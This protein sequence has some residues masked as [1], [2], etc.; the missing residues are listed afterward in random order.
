MVATAAAASTP[1][2]SKRWSQL[3]QSSG[4]SGPLGPSALPQGVAP[5]YPE[6]HPPSPSHTASTPQASSSVPPPFQPQLQQPLLQMPTTRGIYRWMPKSVSPPTLKN[7]AAAGP[8]DEDD[9]HHKLPQQH[10]VNQSQPD[11]RHRTSAGSGTS[12]VGAS[13]FGTKTSG[14]LKESVQKPPTWPPAEDFPRAESTVPND[15]SSE[16]SDIYRNNDGKGTKASKQSPQ[17]REGPEQISYADFVEWQRKLYSNRL[18]L[19]IPPTPQSYAS[20]QQATNQQRFGGDQRNGMNSNPDNDGKGTQASNGHGYGNV[21]AYGNDYGP[22]AMLDPSIPDRYIPSPLSSY[23]LSPM[24]HNPFL[25]RFPPAEESPGSVPKNTSSEEGDTFSLYWPSPPMHNLFLPRSSP[26]QSLD[27]SPTHIPLDLGPAPLG[28]RRL[29]KKNKR[30]LRAAGSGTF[31]SG[32]SSSITRTSGR[33]KESI[34]KPSTWPLAKDFPRAESTVPNDTSSEESDPAADQQDFPPPIHIRTVPNEAPPFMSQPQLQ[35]QPPQPPVQT[36]A[37]PRLS[38]YPSQPASAVSGTGSRI[39][40]PPTWSFPAIDEEIDDD[41]VVVPQQQPFVRP[42]RRRS[43][44]QSP[45]APNVSGQPQPTTR[46][47]VG[48]SSSAIGPAT[49]ADHSVEDIGTQV[50]QISPMPVKVNGH[51]CDVFTGTH[52]IVGKVALKRPRIGAD[53]MDAIR[54]RTHSIV[55]LFI[56]LFPSDQRFQREAE[57]WERLQ[58]R[59]I[60]EYLGSFQRDEHFYFVSPFIENGTLVDYIA[61]NLSVNRV[62]LVRCFCICLKHTAACSAY[63]LAV[64]SCA[65]LQMQLVICMAKK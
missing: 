49:D 61:L 6:F 40:A 17:P 26:P 43:S 24:M 52:S 20:P 63:E 8:Q 58:H 44:F 51:F 7:T 65:R 30:Q 55:I 39:R 13:S 47:T 27:S 46:G 11:P 12:E 42:R 23:L 62:K 48:P 3:R 38:P 21:L 34:Q 57:T 2:P 53:N 45:P 54:V 10:Y 31:K 9:V 1:R 18:D 59:H 15:T 32:A 37:A 25:P 35:V 56:D 22:G 41:V 60:L 5:S 36:Q 19:P 50:T 28:G 14:M 33:L 64:N 29:H 4:G 16:E